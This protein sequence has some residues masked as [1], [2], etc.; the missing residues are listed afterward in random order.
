MTEALA[1]PKIS[2]E[3]D[4]VEDLQRVLRYACTY[5]GK[6]SPESLIK[7][8]VSALSPSDGKIIDAEVMKNINEISLLISPVTIRSLEI[9]ESIEGVQHPDLP[10]QAAI[11]EKFEILMRKWMFYTLI[12][13]VSIVVSALILEAPK[14][15]PSIIPNDELTIVISII[16]QI[17]YS[18]LG[19]LGA[20]AF[21]LRSI[22]NHLS[23]K[24]F[25]FSDDRSYALRATLGF[26][27]GYF[28]PALVT[29]SNLFT[30]VTGTSASLTLVTA[31]FL[32]G[33]AAEAVFT[34]LDSLVITLQNTFSRS[35]TVR[36]NRAK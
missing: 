20:C 32:A 22:L 1:Y 21:I 8:A 7:S 35:T 28:T 5:K 13:L 10:E 30:S 34:A 3:A 6:D 26:I 33:Y 36:D 25:T 2:K 14:I 31:A 15:I 19:Y 16:N 12:G 4:N 24:T 17:K 11:K 18:L 23:S 29:A 9:S 27:L